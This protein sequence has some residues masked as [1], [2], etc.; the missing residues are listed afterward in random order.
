MAIQV[1]WDNWMT[2]KELFK[3]WLG[4]WSTQTFGNWNLNF[5]L[6][7]N[8]GNPQKSRIWW[9]ALVSFTSTFCQLSINIAQPGN[10]LDSQL[11]AICHSAHSCSHLLQLSI[12][13]EFL[14][15]WILEHGDYGSREWLIPLII[16]RQTICLEESCPTIAE[17]KQLSLDSTHSSISREWHSW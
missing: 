13:S 7:E 1:T 15:T 16:W 11:V 8:L 3:F 17:L 9:L 12:R 10:K 2:P 14:W 4:I 6:I 5:V